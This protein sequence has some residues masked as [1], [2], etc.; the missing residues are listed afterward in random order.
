MTNREKYITKHNEYDMLMGIYDRTKG[1]ICP[2]YAISDMK[3]AEHSA[4][5]HQYRD[6]SDDRRRGCAECVQD[7]LNREA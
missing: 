7:W 3:T 1:R 4:R 2:L 6:A 5:C